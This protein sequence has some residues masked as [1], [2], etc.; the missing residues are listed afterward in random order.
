MPGLGDFSGVLRALRVRRD[1]AVN[2]GS[3]VVCGRML[4]ECRQR[5][6]PEG[7]YM[8]YEMTERA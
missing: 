5:V 8:D 6:K 4:Q 2:T 1:I 7:H 3:L